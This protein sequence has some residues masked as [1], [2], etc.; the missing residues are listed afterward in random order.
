MPIPKPK[1]TSTSRDQIVET[2]RQ[3]IRS[4]K[5]HK[6]SFN[7][8]MALVD[9]FID[10]LKSLTSNQ[11][12]QARCQA[13]IQLLEEGYPQRTLA[14]DYIPVYR[15]AIA[16]AVQQGDLPIPPG[17]RPSSE[18]DGQTGS[19]EP[20]HPALL[21]L[22]YDPE[23]YNQ[24]RSQ[25]VKRN[26]E[27]L[28]NL[29]VVPIYRFLERAES[30]LHSSVPEDVAIALCALSGRRYTEVV[31]QGQF[32]P[33]SRYPFLLNFD[34]QLKKKDSQAFLIL[35]LIPADALFTHFQRFRA[36]PAIA[37]LVG[38]AYDHLLV[39]QLHSRV[40]LRMDHAFGD[41][42]GVPQGFERLTIH[43][44]RGVYAA[45]AVHFF[46][47]EMRNEGRFLQQYLGHELGSAA[48]Q[49]YQHYRLVN[50]QGKLIRARGVKLAAY[51]HPDLDI[52]QEDSA[53][54]T[55]ADVHRSDAW[56]ADEGWDDAEELP[57]AAVANGGEED[58]MLEAEEPAPLKGDAD[59]SQIVAEIH[60]LQTSLQAA[61]ETIRQL[62]T[63]RD[64]AIATLDRLRALFRPD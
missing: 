6:L 63:E 44:L 48:I 1:M 50:N 52:D 34:G 10:D 23:T 26:A 28:D 19:A 61:Q 56:V 24:L 43:R 31:A 13:E 35:S 25:T 55:V 11:A 21:F 62:Q 47:P 30:L 46:C 42:L 9:F 17:S 5:S 57:V 36:M 53:I 12:I 49:H 27:R 51:G 14:S 32:Q 39:H 20:Q 40:N 2:F 58:P 41:I 38:L 33:S 45:I 4:G 54:T 29:Q 15:N 18:V 3:R 59:I 37:P 22:K 16:D 60:R 7:A 8:R 64:D